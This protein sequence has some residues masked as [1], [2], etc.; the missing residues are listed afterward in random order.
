MRLVS[1]LAGNFSERN[2]VLHGLLGL[3]A[4][5]NRLMRVWMAEPS[6]CAEPE[7]RPSSVEELAEA[8]VLAFALLG[9]LAIGS[10]LRQELALTN[11]SAPVAAIAPSHRVSVPTG[12]L[13]DGDLLR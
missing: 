2:L 3:L 6:G 4:T 10:R 11:E 7:G 1:S 9:L 5:S 12:G 13:Y 8:P